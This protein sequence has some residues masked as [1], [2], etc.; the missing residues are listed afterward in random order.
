MDVSEFR[1]ATIINDAYNANPCA[2]RES[3]AT[4][5]ALRTGRLI[6]ALGDMLELGGHAAAE[7]RALGRQIGRERP[8]MLYLRGTFSSD[9][10][11]GALE[12]GMQA[13]CIHCCADADEIAMSLKR[14]LRSGDLLLVKGSRGMKMERVV[15][16]LRKEE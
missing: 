4:A 9:V 16:L 15:E 1:G 11:D 2:M 12:A 13:E 7:H 10:R 6:L 5:A 14:L 3:I 8:D